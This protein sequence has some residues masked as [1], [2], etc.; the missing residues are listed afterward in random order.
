MQLSKLKKTVATISRIH[1]SLSNVK[2]TFYPGPT[3]TNGTMININPG[4]PDDAVWLG[5]VEAKATHESGHIAHTDFKVLSVNEDKLKASEM[6]RSINNII[7]DVR[8]E[9]CCIRHLSGAYWVLRR[10]SHLLFDEGYWAYPAQSDSLGKHLFDFL[11]FTGRG[12]GV[13]G[14]EHLEGIGLNAKQ[15]LIDKGVPCQE[16]NQIEGRMS[17]WASLSSSF[18]SFAEAEVIYGLVKQLFNSMPQ[19]PQSGQGASGESGDSQDGQSGQGAG[20]ESGDNQDGQSGQGADSESGDSQDGQPGQGAGGESG[21]SQD[22]QSSQGAGGESGDSQDGQSSQGAGGESGDSQDGQSSQGAGSE[23]DE[24]P[25]EQS[26]SP[27]SQQSGGQGAGQSNPLLF[28]DEASVADGYQDVHDALDK[29]IDTRAEANP[30]SCDVQ[31]AYAKINESPRDDRWMQEPVITRSS[32][33]LSRSLQSA[34]WSKSEAPVS[35]DDSGADFD[36]TLLAGVPAGNNKIFYVEDQVESVK[37]AMVICVDRS[38]S[39]NVHDRQMVANNAAAACA[40]ALEDIGVAVAVLH[41]DNDVILTK[42]FEDTQRASLGKFGQCPMGGTATNWALLA[43]QKLLVT[44]D[45]PRKQVLVITDGE[46]NNVAQVE[47]MVDDLNKDRIDVASIQVEFDKYGGIKHYQTIS[48]IGELPK[49]MSKLV[50]EK[51][52]ASITVY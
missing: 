29:A 44:R 51:A 24:N 34:M 32:R 4:D 16:L 19:M 9:M 48:D 7:E 11:L 28:E 21:D 22:G 33:G 38:G 47:E 3:C 1:T 23:S 6:L 36:E 18:E 12:I 14:Q 46:P 50:R 30:A 42:S 10:M 5:L 43:A 26:G 2:V 40:K 39:M 31:R 37:S 49:T 17:G 27:S 8:M 52:L 45:E 15:M 13:D 41:F 25:G 35:Y 20:G